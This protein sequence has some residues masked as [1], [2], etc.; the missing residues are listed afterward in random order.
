MVCD[1]KEDKKPQLIGKIENEIENIDKRMKKVEN[2]LD[3]ELKNLI[4]GKTL[5]TVYKEKE[6]IPKIK[7][8]YKRLQVA[9]AQSQE[10][11]SYWGEYIYDP[12]D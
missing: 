2:Q 10:I 1:I 9:E 4:D 3:M 7:K 11:L 6:L 12:H 8:I 5:N